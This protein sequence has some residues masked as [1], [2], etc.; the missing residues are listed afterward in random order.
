MAREVTPHFTFDWKEI[1]TRGFLHKIENDGT[2]NFYI[3]E[4]S[5]RPLGGV[6]NSPG[7]EGEKRLRKAIFW[8]C[9]VTKHTSCGGK[10]EIFFLSGALDNLIL[11][12][13]YQN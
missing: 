13:S 9:D 12:G 4:I 10:S 11:G 2:T 5:I 1:K 3:C 8:V 7:R 6:E